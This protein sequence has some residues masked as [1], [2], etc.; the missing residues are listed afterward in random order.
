MNGIIWSFFTNG[1][2][3]GHL[4]GILLDRLTFKMDILV[5]IYM[6]GNFAGY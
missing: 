2:F 3:G 1:C 5:S 6:C 4:S